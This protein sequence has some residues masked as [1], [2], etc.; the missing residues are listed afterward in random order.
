MLGGMD[1]EMAKMSTLGDLLQGSGWV[2]SLT[3]SGIVGPGIAQNMVKGTQLIKS[4][5]SHQV[6]L[7]ALWILSKKAKEE[8][9][10]SCAMV[11][12]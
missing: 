1:T 6:T 7:A 3:Q 12:G 4:R 9:L 8:I 10:Q 2:T 11:A 5:Y